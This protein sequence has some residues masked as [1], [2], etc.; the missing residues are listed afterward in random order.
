MNIVTREMNQ[1]WR[2]VEEAEKRQVNEEAVK[3]WLGDVKDVYYDLIDV[4]NEWDTVEMESQLRRLGLWLLGPL[5]KCL[6][7]H[8]FGREVEKLTRQIQSF[9]CAGERLKLYK[10]SIEGGRDEEERD[11]WLERQVV[12]SDVVKA[13]M[14]GRDDEA[15]ILRSKL[16]SLQEDIHYLSLVGIAGIGKTSVAQTVYNQ[17]AVQRRFDLKV[18]INVSHDFNLFTIARI[19]IQSEPDR[20]SVIP[21]DVVELQFLLQCVRQIIQ[22]KRFLFVLD[23]V[24]TEDDAFWQKFRGI[25]KLGAPGSAILITTRKETVAHYAGCKPRDIMR[26]DSLSDQDCWSII[27]DFVFNSSTERASAFA[28]VGREIANKCE[29]LPVVAKSLAGILRSRKSMQQWLEVLQID[30]RQTSSNHPVEITPSLM[31]SYYFLPSPLRKCLLYC[32]IFPKDHIIDVDK[33]IKLW[34]AQDYSDTHDE[35]ETEA[36]DTHDRMETKAAGYFQE[37]LNRSFFHELKKDGKDNLTCK[38]VGVISDFIQVLAENECCILHADDKMEFEDSISLTKPRHMTIKVASQASLPGDIG[39]T[40]KLHTLIVLA[41]YSYTDPSTLSNLLSQ[42]G[43]LRALDLSSCS[44]RELRIKVGSLLHL[45]YLDLSFNRDLKKLPKEICDLYFLQTLNLNG[46]DSLLKLPKGIGK[47]SNLR[48]LEILWTKSLSYLPKGIASLTSLRTLNRFFGNDGV[49]SKACNF[50]DLSRL[51]HLQGCISIDGLG[52]ATDVDL[53]K[54]CLKKKEEIFG[55]DLWFSRVG[56]ESDQPNYGL[57]MSFERND[58]DVLEALE[59]PPTLKCLGIH[60]YTSSLFPQW[61]TKLQQLRQLMLS[62]FSGCV[63][64]PALGKL[65][66]LQSLEI[67]NMTKLEEVGADFLGIESEEDV[68]FPKLKKLHFHMLTSWEKWED[69]PEEGRTLSIM[70]QLSSV[71]ITSCTKIKALPNYI[72]NK[73]ELISVTV[74][75]CPS[76][77]VEG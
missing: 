56:Y 41:E 4:M 10:H 17:R 9:S 66:D 48:H 45:R 60:Y 68:S 54:E 37:L 53:A 67:R 19:I 32:S 38:L 39:D 24:R 69:I 77:E 51:N 28:K 74:E 62:E 23:D 3:K 15:K 5:K 57:H 34:I 76:F 44:V 16:I 14:Y 25:C 20:A 70:P 29:G 6:Y 49:D 26:L 50:G 55:L 27:R 43:R 7:Y 47:L 33:L 61:I 36:S 12:S 21:L 42:C 31:L 58:S 59:P 13:K 63:N 75:D 1:C 46:C 73:R 52:A 30:I 18:W 64:L 22:G 11:Y 2:Q 8:D 35:M 40:S 72:Q 71:S 65:N